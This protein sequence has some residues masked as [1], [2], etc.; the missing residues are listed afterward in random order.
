APEIGS[1]RC[2]GSSGPT[3][4]RGGRMSLQT[5]RTSSVPT[6]SNTAF[7]VEPYTPNIGAL[8][9]GVDLARP[10]GAAT[11]VELRQALLQYGVLFFREQALGPDQVLEVARIFG[12]PL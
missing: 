5:L 2:D 4:T 8:V 1:G 10:L 7:T 9:S 6:G 3:P 11:R 12:A